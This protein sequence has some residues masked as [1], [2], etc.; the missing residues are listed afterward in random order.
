M[1]FFQV[2]LGW[3]VLS[4]FYS[5]SCS[6]KEPLRDVAQ[7]L[8]RLLV[9]CHLSVIKAL[10]ETTYW[11]HPVAWPIILSSTTWLLI[12]WALFPLWC[13]SNSNTGRH[14][15]L[16]QWLILVFCVTDLSAECEALHHWFVCHC[17]D[18]CVTDYRVG[19]KSDTS[20]NYITLYE[21]YHFYWPTL[22]ILIYHC[23]AWW[24][25]GC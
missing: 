21:R 8:Y 11:S 22:Y 25:H 6:R 3:P 20:T 9:F 14:I 19:Q 4:W 17:I 2:Y 13:L 1:S 7:A 5:S 12:E 15:F 24:R 16:L 18:P 10:K 23:R